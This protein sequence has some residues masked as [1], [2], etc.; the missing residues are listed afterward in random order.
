MSRGGGVAGKPGVCIVMDSAEKVQ[1]GVARLRVV[2]PVHN[3]EKFVEE[4]LESVLAELPIDGEVVVIDDGSVD[5]SPL[6]IAEIMRR[7]PRVRVMRNES[8]QGVSRAL[9]LGITDGEAVEFVAVAEHDDVVLA[10]R[11][12]AQMAALAA[13]PTLGAVSSEGR[14]LGPSGR[15]AGRVS[16]GPKSPEEF[17]QMRRAG[18]EILIPH[19]AIMYRREAVV[20]AGLYDPEFDSAQD[21]E[22]IN[23]VVY[24]AGWTVQ[25]LATP[26]VLYRIHDA[27]MS[28][29]HIS[30]Q[31]MMTR[32]IVYRNR[33]Q[34]DSVPFDTFED[35]KLKNQPDWK[36]RVTWYR[37]DTGALRYR[38]AGLAW[39]TRRPLSFVGNM[40]AASILHPKWV[41]MKLRV[42]RGR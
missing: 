31:R 30:A 42:A 22:L 35:W 3:A 23:R 5:A 36:T 28:F 27:S 32:Y 10:G 14:Y 38:Q 29:S 20:A 33:A 8:A 15:I 6:R 26:H 4:A 40:A 1:A 19:P 39:L 25:T 41:L 16:V 7:D 24:A 37:K 9:N 21:L 2:M 34:L 11:F 12:A 18:R 17:E 13:D